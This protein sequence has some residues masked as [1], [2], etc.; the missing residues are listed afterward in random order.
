LLFVKFITSGKQVFA[1]EAEHVRLSG[2][3]TGE[4]QMTGITL[5]LAMQ[6]ALLTSGSDPYSQAY[7]AA[8]TN[9]QPLVVLVGTD[10]CPGCRTM[11]Q[12][13]LPRLTG[14][15]KLR[16][17]NFCHVNSDDNWNLASKLLVG[18]TIPQLVVFT[19]TPEGWKREQLV[20]A[21]PEEQVEAV[22]DRA[23][24]TAQ[25][26]TNVSMTSTKVESRVE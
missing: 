24:Q 9:G 17:V 10:W 18:D 19:K 25:L 12:G 11:K 21:K 6:A 8:Q 5:S 26:A 14:R 7:H 3:H 15:G 23:V 22:L 2:S 16:N 20:G 13:V 4:F 1:N